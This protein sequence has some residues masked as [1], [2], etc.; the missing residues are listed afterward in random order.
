MPTFPIETT[1]EEVARALSSQIKG[2]NVIITGAS[3]ESLGFGAAQTI[4]T[5][6]PGLIVLTARKLPV[7]EEAKAEILKQS[8]KANI[9]LLDFDLGSQASV[10][11]AAERVK[12]LGERF[13][14]LINCAGIMATPYTLTPEG[15]ESQFG[16][17]HIGHFLFT[18][19]LVP[20]LNDGASIVNVSSSGYQLGPILWDDLSFKKT[21]YNKWHAYGQ[22]KAA[23]ILFSAAIARKLA[24]RGIISF[25]VHPGTIR[26]KIGRH[27]TQEDYDLFAN[28]PLRIKEPEQGPANMLIAAFD[29]SIRDHNGSYIH[30]DN[31]VTPISEEFAY[32]FGKENEDRLW[33][34]SEK[35]VNQ[36]FS[37]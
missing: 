35:L 8:P 24:N 2:K 6:E 18:N 15:I 10:R 22:S 36:E 31:R 17:N 19:L 5:K 9:K 32:A 21:P 30:D 29:T 7:L 23:N 3:P 37:Y 28:T 1:A 14:V 34:L 4:A 25:G 20:V 26:T 16:T 27:M 11:E 12:A 33:V 13:D